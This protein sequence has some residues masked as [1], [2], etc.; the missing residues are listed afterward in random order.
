MGKKKTHEA[1]AAAPDFG[2]PEKVAEKYEPR[3]GLVLKFVSR[4][5]G[6]VDLRQVTLK[7]AA[8]L[9]EAGY[10]IEKKVE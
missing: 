7:Q 8:E 5:F 6:T 4:E 9:T 3:K 1:P 10:L 2:L